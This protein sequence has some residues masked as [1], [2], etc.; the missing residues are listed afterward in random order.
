ML[1]LH[2]FISH[3]LCSYSLALTVTLFPAH[4][5]IHLGSEGTLLI[6]WVFSSLGFLGY[7]IHYAMLC[8]DDTPYKPHSFYAT[9]I[10]IVSHV[11]LASLLYRLDW[12]LVSHFRCDL[13]AQA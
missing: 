1:V 4:T 7:W 8:H 6:N 5:P 11:L 2:F 12:F 13:N 3:I 9:V 10:V